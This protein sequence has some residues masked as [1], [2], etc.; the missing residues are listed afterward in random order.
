[1]FQGVK[2]SLDRRIV[3]GATCPAHALLDEQDFVMT[4]K[5]LRSELATVIAVKD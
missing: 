4:D 3:I 5:L 2:M 1:M